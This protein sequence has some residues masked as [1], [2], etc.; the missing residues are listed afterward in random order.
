MV[1]RTVQVELVEAVFGGI[2]PRDGWLLPENRGK[3]KHAVCRHCHGDDGLVLPRHASFASAVGAVDVHAVVE[4]RD[5]NVVDRAERAP[6][7]ASV[8]DAPRPAG[9]EGSFHCALGGADAWDAS[10]REENK[11][12]SSSEAMWASRAATYS[13]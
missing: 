5:E 4:R 2:A 7:L 11:G 8:F 1:L 12:S 13:T 9:L 6:R 3:R 10:E